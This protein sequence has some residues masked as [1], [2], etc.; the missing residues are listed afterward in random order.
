MSTEKVFDLGDVSKE[1]KDRG[2]IPFDQ[3]PKTHP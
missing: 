1:T 3:A 2:P